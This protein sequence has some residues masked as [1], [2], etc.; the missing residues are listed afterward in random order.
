[1][2]FKREVAVENDRKP[3]ISSCQTAC[4]EEREKGEHGTE[5]K[6]NYYSLCGQGHGALVLSRGVHMKDGEM[7]RNLV[8]VLVVIEAL[9][10]HLVCVES[11]DKKTGE[12]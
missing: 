5:N 8:H 4:K 10:T 7:P 11:K 3:I 12:L 6:M 9:E 2:W 1:M